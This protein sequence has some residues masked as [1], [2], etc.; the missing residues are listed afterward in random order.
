MGL[1]FSF[2]SQNQV[3]RQVQLG[4]L[5]QC[6]LRSLLKETQPLV[7]SHIPQLYSLVNVSEVPCLRKQQQQTASKLIEK[8]TNPTS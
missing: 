7:L 3:P 4:L 8:P 5:E 1:A 2:P 6:E